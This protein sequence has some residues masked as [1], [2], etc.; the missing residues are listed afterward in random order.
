M[1]VSMSGLADDL[2]AESAVLRGLLVPLDEDG[3]RQPTPAAGWS[4][5][6]QV[7]HLAWFD[8]AAL[9][10]ALQPEAFAAEQ[11]D[12]D[13]DGVAAAY[14]DR[15]G[16]EV[17][18]WF[19]DAR[20]RLLTA[21]RALDPALRAPWYGPPMSAASAL[22]A[23]IMETWAHG[24]DVADTL[25]LKREPTARL[26]HVAHIGDRRPRVQ[27]CR[28]RAR[29][30]HGTDPGGAR[31]ARRRHVDWGPDA[32]DRVVG[33]ALD[34]C[35]VVTQRR[36]LADT[37][38][39]GDRARRD[40]VDELRP[41]VCGA[42]GPRP[43]AVMRP[44]RIANCSGFYGD[45]LAAAREMVEGGPIDVLT[46]DY[47][48]E[49]TM[50]ILGKARRSDPAAGYARTFLRPDGG[51][52]RAPASTAASRSWPT[53]AGSTRPGWP[54]SCGAGRPAGLPQRRPRRGRRPPRRLAELQATGTSSPTWPP[55]GTLAEAGVPVT[56]NAYL[57]GWGIAAALRAGAD[58]VV[59]GRVTDAALVVGPAAW[60]TAGRPT[61]GTRSPGAVV[62]GHIIECGP[63]AT[64]GNYAFFDEMPD[65]AHPGFPIAEMAADG[66]VVITKHPGH[67]RRWSRSARSPRSCCTRSPR[68]AY[69]D[70]DV[71]ARFDTVALAQEGPDRVARHRHPRRARRPTTLKV[72][73]N[74]LG[75]Y[76][77]TMTLRPHRPRHRGQGRGPRSLLFARARRQATASPRS[78]CGCRS[79]GRRADER[80]GT[81]H[82]TVTVKDPD[83]G[84][85]GR[86][87]LRTRSLVAGAGRATPAST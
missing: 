78:S 51:G 7:T 50:L 76:R 84:Q 80:P 16:A 14:R 9:R 2:A 10:S 87:L 54:P 4:V 81:A 41:G 49:L 15:S 18:A 48:A 86:A 79:T 12:P 66:T 31:R 72:A 44:V 47:L 21:F 67:R 45:R 69:L 34:F 85:V 57:G 22:T 26:R 38:V 82:L 65:P 56:A 46:G 40:R 17:L 36:H 75:G 29:G 61:T 70:P 3:W 8:E 71:V 11:A 63:Q 83:R 6:D 35:L 59:S 30:A 37:A 42:C 5:L 74:Y 68:P 32:A 62:A 53:R 58:V 25:G 13:P 28:Q 19:D 55:A 33:P 20:S 39:G 52:A 43:G 77:N 73:L 23:R 1:P 64:G 27:L 60:A 24:Q